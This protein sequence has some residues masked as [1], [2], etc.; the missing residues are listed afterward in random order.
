MREENTFDPEDDDEI[1]F[2]DLAASDP[3]WGH[4]QSQEEHE[5][6]SEECGSV[7]RPRTFLVVSLGAQGNGAPWPVLVMLC[8]AGTLQPPVVTPGEHA[9]LFRVEA[10]ED[11]KAQADGDMVRIR[12]VFQLLAEDI[13][14]DVEVVTDKEQQ[15]GSSPE[16]E[17]K[18]VEEQCPGKAWRPE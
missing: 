7:L 1:Q 15:Q 2:K 13:I 3:G 16:L 5:R 11:S 14:L 10:G 18:T 9:T 17:E 12:Q 6:Q 4:G 8:V